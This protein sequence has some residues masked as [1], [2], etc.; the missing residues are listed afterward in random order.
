MRLTHR[1]F[2]LILLVIWPATVLSNGADTRYTLAIAQGLRH[3]ALI[4]LAAKTSH[5]ILFAANADSEDIV[6]GL[7]GRYTFIEALELLLQSSGLRYSFAGSQIRIERKSSPA[8]ILPR[9]TVQGYLRDD[10]ARISD[11]DDSQA[12]FPLYQVP[13]SIQSVSE[14]YMDDIDARN[15]SDVISYLGGI[16]YLETARGIHPQ[17]YSR[18]LETPFSI[19]GKFYWRTILVPDASVLERVDIVQG[20]SANYLQ[21]GGM[22]N[23]VIKKPS[24]DSSVELLLKGGSYDFFRSEIDLNLS[25]K[26]TNKKAVRL[27]AAAETQNHVK[28]FAFR[29][30]VVFAPSFAYE[31]SEQGRLSI[32]AYHQ[33]EQEYPNT[34]TYHESLLSERLPREQTM[35]LPWGTSTT[36]DSIAAIDLNIGNWKAWALS[37]GGNWNYTKTDGW[38]SQVIPAQGSGGVSE[39]RLSFVKDLYTKSYGIDLSAERSGEIFSQATL[40]RVGLDYQHADQYSP[41]YATTLI[42]ND[43]N[44]YRPDYSYARPREGRRLGSYQ[45]ITDFVG[46]YITQNIYIDDWLTVFADLRYE[47]M[48]SSGRFIYPGF[49]LDWRIKGHY[50]EYTSQLGI[51]TQFTDSFSSHISYFESF[52]H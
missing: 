36:R 33:L 8:V 20:P 10:I 15:V 24:K 39:L 26:G 49:G 6:A 37:A 27:I 45:H 7:N 34:S 30:K 29:K 4:E 43:F 16:E 44:V 11:T 32:F 13:L 5:E 40:F 51:N 48:L 25:S 31:F 47:D 23:F 2:F 35:G 1:A 19:D 22:L 12:R 21:P 3:D 41:E 14:D 18:G 46:I 38:Y 52:T 28:K 42:T 9:I 50:K 17:F